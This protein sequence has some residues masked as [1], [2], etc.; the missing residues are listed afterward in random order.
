M[1]GGVKLLTR[2]PSENGGGVATDVGGSEK[3]SVEMYPP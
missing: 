2:K 1:F 3:P